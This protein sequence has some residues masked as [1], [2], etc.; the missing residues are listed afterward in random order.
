M[1][2]DFKE[3]Q[4]VRIP[5]FYGGEK[6]TAARMFADEKGKIMVGR[7]EPGASIGVHTHT[8]SS[9]IIYVLSGEGKAFFDGAWEAV[10]SGQC[11]YCPKGHT[12]GLNNDGGEDLVF[13][14]AVPEQ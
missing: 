4:E 3:L 2:I 7:L 5:Q 10:G 12:H 6:E 1:V 8:T 13:F 14:A 9:E 11:H